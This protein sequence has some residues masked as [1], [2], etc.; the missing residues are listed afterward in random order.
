MLDPDG[1]VRLAIVGAGRMGAFHARSLALAGPRASGVDVVA[2]ADASQRS[3]D[4]VS[5]VVV[6][7]AAY[8]SADEAFAHPGLEACLIATPTPTHPALVRQAL[9]AGL[10]V[11]CEKP[12]SL[13]P[14]ESEALGCAAADAG[15][16]LQVGFWRRFSPPWQRARDAIADGRIG[17][18]LMVRLAQWDADP[19]PASF[20][21]PAVSGGLAVDCGVHEFD[22]A[23]WLTSCRIERVRAWPLPTIDRGI[24][25]VGDIDNLV[26]VLELSGGAVATVDLSR[27]ARY[28]DDVRTEVLG[29]QGALLVDLLPTGRTRIGTA[30][31]MT[32]L[33][34]SDVADATAAGVVAQMAAFAAAVRGQVVDLPGATASARA[35]AVAHAVRRAAETGAAVDLPPGV[36]V[37]PEPA[38]AAG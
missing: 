24:A 9:A 13:D 19:P 29:S 22:L 14:A 34:R 6:G 38:G 15:R 1:M 5:A 12:L 4:A 25:E 21:D 35:T 33:P 2:V 23:E 36:V 20:C 16:V 32:T 31:G 11:L 26:V 28:G 3:L 10:H 8:A 7:A 27:N 18:P 30:D 37:P 17:R